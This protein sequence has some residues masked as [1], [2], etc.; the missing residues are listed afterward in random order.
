[1]QVPKQDASAYLHDDS[2]VLPLN[3]SIEERGGEGGRLVYKEGEIVNINI[4]SRFNMGV[5]ELTKNAHGSSNN[6]SSKRYLSN[7]YQSPS[8]P[9]AATMRNHDIDD[10]EKDELLASLDHI[11]SIMDHEKDSIKIPKKLKPH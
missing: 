7:D 6:V 5:V 11:P 3:E 10:S 9:L 8:P 2:L 1:M 4:N